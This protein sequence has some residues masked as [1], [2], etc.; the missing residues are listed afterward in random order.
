MLAYVGV[1]RQ[2]SRDRLAQL[3]AWP[4]EE[5][6]LTDEPQLCRSLEHAASV[7]HARRILVVWGDSDEPHVGTVLWHGGACESRRDWSLDCDRLVAAELSAATFMASGPE[8]RWVELKSGRQRIARPALDPDIAR[9]FAVE[10]F[11]TAAF[12]SGR[13]RGR[14]FML[15][16]RRYSEGLLLLTE[17]VALRI[18]VEL[19]H[20][21][22]RR[23]LANAARAQERAQL[24]RDIHDSIL[25]DLAA[26]DLQLKSM[27]SQVPAT[28]RTQLAEVG[29]LI[30]SQQKRIRSFVDTVTQ[31]PLRVPP[32]DLQHQL[33]SF[34]EQLAQ[35]WRCRVDLVLDP[36]DLQ[37]GPE[38]SYHIC[39]ML[40]EA[41][42]N[43][44]RH[45]G[46]S[47]VGVTIRRDNGGLEIAIDDNGRGL[48]V[49]GPGA[50]APSEPAEPISLRQRVQELGGSLKLQNSVAGLGLSISLPVPP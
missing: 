46:A 18:G 1:F 14:V 24:A 29:T 19:E 15:E 32:A 38:L 26:A 41:T 27:L 47:R 39:L 12:D 28:A 35:Q 42:A 5:A 25:Q 43:A 10:A 20:F 8:G 23:D 6:S 37:P 36:P 30:S 9:A 17:I 3:A 21:G 13:F 11:A 49:P 44:V 45:G 2:R 33:Q 34:A 50:Q 4:P 22:L 31:K 40:A 7:L 16:P 48:G